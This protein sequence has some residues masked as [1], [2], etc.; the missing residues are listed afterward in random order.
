MIESIGNA[1]T[2]VGWILIPFSFVGYFLIGLIA[3]KWKMRYKVKLVKAIWYILNVVLSLTQDVTVENI[4]IMILCFE[5]YD[6]I[7]DYFEGKNQKL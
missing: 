3:Y 2:H 1:L 4:A 6:A 5:S 7:L